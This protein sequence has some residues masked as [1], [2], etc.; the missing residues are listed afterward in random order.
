VSFGKK[1]CTLLFNYMAYK[2]YKDILCRS[3]KKCAHFY[4]ITWP[5]KST[6]TFCVVRK[7]IVSCV[8]GTFSFKLQDIRERKRK[9]IGWNSQQMGKGL[10]VIEISDLPEQ[11]HLPSKKSSKSTSKR[12]NG[13]SRVS[14]DVQLPRLYQDETQLPC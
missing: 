13:T 10:Y 4:L 9:K 8:V 12:A 2:K 5:T 1:L 11:T 7:K 3:E 6:K 14:S